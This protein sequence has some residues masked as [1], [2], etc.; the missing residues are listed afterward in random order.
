[1]LLITGIK[2][3]EKNCSTPPSFLCILR[4]PCWFC[5]HHNWMLGVVHTF[6]YLSDKGIWT[7]YANVLPMQSLSIYFSECNWWIKNAEPNKGGV[8][9]GVW[10]YG[11]RKGVLLYPKNWLV[12]N[13]ITCLSMLGA[14]GKRL[15][16]WLCGAVEL[17]CLSILEAV[18]WRM[19]L[20]VVIA[21]FVIA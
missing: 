4:S 13:N 14:L 18:K 21:I 20:A 12:P 3:I 9:K 1:M 15:C 17:H 6:C 10:R 2:N 7:S 16:T 11:R 8:G 19:I 5:D